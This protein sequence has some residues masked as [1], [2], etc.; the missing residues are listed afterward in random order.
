MLFGNS[1][2]SEECCCCYL[3]SC[4]KYLMIFVPLSSW[5][6]SCHNLSLEFDMPERECRDFWLVWQQICESL[7]YCHLGSKTDTFDV[8]LLVEVCGRLRR[9]KFPYAVPLVSL[10]DGFVGCWIAVHLATSRPAAMQI[11]SSTADSKIWTDCC[12]KGRSPRWRAENCR[13]L[14]FR[15]VCTMSSV[16]LSVFCKVA[17][18]R[19]R[20]AS[21]NTFDVV[22]ASSITTFLREWSVRC[23]WREYD[24]FGLWTPRVTN[25]SIRLLPVC[26]SCTVQR[27]AVQSAAC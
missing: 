18:K 12:N 3:I 24:L 17:C 1:W 2:A 7:W 5:L 6:R 27:C 10:E 25:L 14:S 21:V 22:P 9:I 13:Q 8:G 19:L 15:R 4:V 26:T 20:S 16:V 23:L 11:S